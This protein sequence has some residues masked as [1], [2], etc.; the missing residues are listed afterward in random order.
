MLFSGL[1]LTQEKISVNHAK[2]SVPLGDLPH[3]FSLWSKWARREE[4]GGY[5]WSRRFPT[6]VRSRSESTCV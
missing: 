6:T 5:E 4:K 3:P 2:S 1:R